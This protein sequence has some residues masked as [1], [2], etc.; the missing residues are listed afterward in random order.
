MYECYVLKRM[1]IRMLQ[2]LLGPTLNY[3]VHNYSELA[4]NQHL[5]RSSDIT[6]WLLKSAC[7]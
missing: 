6:A 3:V 2:H 5:L 4:H 7:Y 1:N